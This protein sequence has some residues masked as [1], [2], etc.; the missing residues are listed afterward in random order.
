M[1]VLALALFA[2]ATADVS[3]HEIVLPA[4]AD[5]AILTAAD[6]N[7]DGRPDLIVSNPE[8]GAVTILLNDGGGRFHSAMVSPFNSGPSPN[9]FAVS[10]FNH[11]G[12][13][14]L[15]VVNTQTPFIA[16]FSTTGVAA[17][18]P[19]PA[20][21]SARHP[22]RTRMASRRPILPAEALST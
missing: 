10:D 16:S 19:R 18:A 21:Q 12:H 9:D 7:E 6:V 17:S 11:D 14:D 20:R 3:F 8:A 15:A 13:R 2:A 4:G 5:A 1:K 22:L